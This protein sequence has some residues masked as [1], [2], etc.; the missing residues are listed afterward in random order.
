MRFG[1]NT[2]IWTG[3]FEPAHL[4]LLPTVKERGFDGIEIAAFSI[5]GLPLA[6][7]RKAL[8]ENRLDCTFCTALPP[9]ANAV[10]G[11]AAERKRAE[12]HVESCVKAAAE[13]GAKILS[14]PLYSPVG[15]VTGRRRTEEEWKRGVDFLS[16]LRPVLAANDVA[17]A[18]EPLNRFETFFLNTV[19]D[20]VR[21]CTE[22]ND[23][24]VGILFD[25]FHANV[26]E[27][28]LPAALRSA[29]PY[30]KNVHTSENDR[31][32]PGTGHIPWA[33][34]FQAMRD[35]QYDGWLVIESFA[36][37]VKEI[38]TAA[39]IWRDL[40]PSPEHIAFEGLKFL[41]QSAARAAAANQALA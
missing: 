39:S 40:A 27:R 8:E 26:E 20:A 16:S 32:T 23:P 22:V 3:A 17:L 33:G 36:Y 5:E 18:I 4:S 1:V 37:T 28:D 7:I 34:V 38:A 6:A 30:L 9:G 11:D 13:L 31:G 10:S 14:G 15:F 19:A 25:T 41:K 21:L 24:R 35:V 2:L 29:G 12:A